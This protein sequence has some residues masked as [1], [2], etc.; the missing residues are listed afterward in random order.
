[1]PT[2]L[3]RR[4]PG[5][6]LPWIP[7]GSWPSPVREARPEGGGSLW[8]KDEGLV[9]PEYG[10][11]KV[12]KLEWLLGDAR[13]QGIADLLTIGAVGSHHVIATASFGRAHGFR[14]F[15]VLVPQPDTAHV[16]ENARLIDALTE[17]W[18]AS[19]V[20]PA[21]PIAWL[22]EWV[23]IRLVGGRPVYPIAAGGSDAVGTLGWVAAGLE[24]AEDVAA[25]RIPAPKTVVTAMGSAGTA[26]GLWLGLRLGGLDAEVVGVRVF[27]RVVTHARRARKLA[28][29]A[30]ERLR[31]A[32]ADPGPF[33]DGHVTVEHGWFGAGYGTTDPQVEAA[34][35]AGRALG[36]APD[37][38]YTARALG[39]ALALRGP[40]PTLLVWT[41]NGRPVDGWLAEALPG[42]PAGMR[43]LLR[44]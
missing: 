22:R 31:A 21:A 19:E 35:A 44:Q 40:G 16:R 37:V 8:I 25:G 23:A 20:V 32:G 38:T 41:L 6:T 4:F 14:T 39:A 30:W 7:L 13:D 36:L 28:Q 11:N 17:G 9:S 34:M 24:I 1:M 10:G 33:P 29:A 26:G 42:V 3:H 43:G 15:A 5:L 2:A 27:D 12:R 18:I